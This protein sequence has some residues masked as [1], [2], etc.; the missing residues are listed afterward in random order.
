MNR[1]RVRAV[2]AAAAAAAAAGGVGAGLAVAAGRSSGRAPTPSGPGRAGFAW[3]RP[4]TGVS[5]YPWMAGPSGYS[6]MMGGAG[7]PGWMRGGTPPGYMTG[8]GTDPGKVM[9]SLRAGAP[10]PRE[11]QSDS[12]RIGE[13][14]PTGASP[15]RAS[16]RSTSTSSTVHLVALASRSGGPDE[17]FRIAGMVNRTLA[18]RAGAYVNVELVNADQDSAHGLVVTRAGAAS[19]WVPT[20]TAAPTFSGSALWFPGDPTCAGMHEET[21]AFT[22]TTPGPCRY[23]GAVP[24]HDE[25]GMV[26]TFVVQGRR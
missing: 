16:R 2:L 3:H 19:S 10:A 4:M 6:S 23:R 18:V 13:E 26:G 14:V 25:K 15:D 1:R 20:T 12:T 21:L 5:P 24:G 7:A 8:T 11:R 17:T 9:G 22:A